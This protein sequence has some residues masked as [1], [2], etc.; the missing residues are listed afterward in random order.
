MASSHKRIAGTEGEYDRSIV[1]F[2]FLDQLSQRN[3]PT[4]RNLSDSPGIGCAGWFAIE[5]LSPTYRGTELAGPPRFEMIALS[6]S[7]I[8]FTIIRSYG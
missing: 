8:P 2:E 7:K 3:P 5:I 6:L 4:H 1:F